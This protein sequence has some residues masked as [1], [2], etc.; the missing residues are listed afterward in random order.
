[1]IDGRFRFDNYVVGSANRLAVS[2]AK[3]V[4]ESPGTVY[5]PLFIYSGSGMGKTHLMGALGFAI[6][7]MHPELQVEYLSLDD[8]V[9][10][11]NAAIGA[12]QADSF[13]RRWQGVGALLL[14]DVQ[15]LTGRTETQSEMLRVLNALQASGRQIVMT[16][17]RPPS[18]IADVDQRLLTR[19]AGGLTVD[20]GAPDLETRIAILQN[21]CTERSLTF[22]P[23]VLEELAR[24]PSANVRELQGALNRLIA[25]Q[26]IAER[27]I[28]AEDVRR[29]NAMNVAAEPVD[30]FASFVSDLAVAVAQTVEEWRVR[31]GERIAHWSGEGFRTDLLERALELPEVPDVDGLEARFASACERLRVIE[32][33]AIRLDPKFT[34]LA[35]F[36]DP[37]RLADAEDLLLRAYAL[38]E[39]PPPPNPEFTLERLVSTP[40][41]H[42]AM[43]S[44]AG[45]VAAPAA[46]YNP[47][48]ITGPGGSGKTHLLHAIGNALRA[49]DK[50][51]WTVACTDIE[52]F[53]RELIE[54]LQADTMAR[55]RA[56]YRACDALLIDDVH[57]LAGKERAQEELF[58]LFNAMHDARKQVVFASAV[59]PSHLTDIAPRLRSRLDG[60]LVVELGRVSDAE[61]IARHTPVPPGDEAAAPT[62]DTRPARTRIATP[63]PA[64]PALQTREGIDT[65]FLDPEKLVTD[66]P[67]VDGR[68]VEETH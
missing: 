16:S 34:G 50:G 18:E 7:S 44:A 23:G 65:Y 13:K 37:E 8:F 43:R 64:M 56:R 41:N 12:G 52:T 35:V 54:A 68:I 46:Q 26:S 49:R 63:V 59:L 48:V 27:P 11:L 5:N 55:W 25:Q 3:A 53:T 40:A 6:R 30:E 22:S 58:H 19:L 38:C 51:T 17:D 32:G 61:R 24:N 47:L 31:L 62:I 10:Q 45:I 66:W 15:F 14:D 2:A 21:K 42:L 36:R 33:D 1:M 39:P 20:I 9:D 28:R 67:D 60:G 29:A 4:V 57:L